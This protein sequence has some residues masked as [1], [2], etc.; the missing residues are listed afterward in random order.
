MIIT[1]KTEDQEEEIALQLEN[2]GYLLIDYKVVRQKKS[3]AIKITIFQEGGVTHQD[4]KSTTKIVQQFIEENNIY[5]DFGI[6]V[7]SPGIHRSLK[8]LRELRAFQG[9]KVLISYQDNTQVLQEIGLLKESSQQ[10]INILTEAQEE[11]AFPSEMIKKIR[12]AD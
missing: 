8:T 12:L 9:R 2:N 4:C 5:S 7:S 1:N 11:K 6:E 3:I 10:Q